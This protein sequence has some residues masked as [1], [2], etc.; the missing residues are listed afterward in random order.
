MYV[1]KA[2]RADSDVCAAYITYV[3]DIRQIIDRTVPVLNTGNDNAVDTAIII[4]IIP[5]SS[6]GLFKN[7]VGPTIS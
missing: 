1:T 5:Y 2:E 3:T 6:V 7:R 4:I